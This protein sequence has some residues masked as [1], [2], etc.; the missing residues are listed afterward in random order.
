MQMILVVDDDPG[1]RQLLVRL[2]MRDG[3]PAEGFGTAAQ[4][5][6]ALG[7]F[8]AYDD[9]LVLMDVSLHPGDVY[10]DGCEAGRAFARQFPGIRLVFMSGHGAE[11]ILARC[12]GHPPY[13]TKPMPAEFTDTVR[14][15]M[16]APPWKP[17]QQN[18]RRK[19]DRHASD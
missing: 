19:G 13:I 12:G 6:M 15:H 5:E 18:D 1:V 8:S 17:T 7:G 10:P 16:N 11:G 3:L 4:A 14:L 9:V 2:L